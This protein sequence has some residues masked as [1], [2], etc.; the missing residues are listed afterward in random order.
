MKLQ[1]LMLSASLFAVVA[2]AKAEAGGSFTVE[3]KTFELL[4]AYA[5]TCPNPYDKT[6]PAT[7]ITFS[8]RK[9]DAKAIKSADNPASALRDAVNSYL[10][11]QE[12]RPSS[13][14]VTFARLAPDSPIADI[15]YSIPE[16]SSQASSN[17]AGYV[18]DLKRNDDKRIEG[19]LLSKDPA[20]KTKKYGGGF[21]DL[22]FALDVDPECL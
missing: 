6:K 21:F 13:V 7:V 20:N 3:G 5:Y 1:M 9:I 15:S 14:Q 8:V 18:L 17:I 19:T 16:L 22:Q 2:N 11:E 4:S 12:A 10:P